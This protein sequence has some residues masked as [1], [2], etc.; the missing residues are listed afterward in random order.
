MPIITKKY[1]FCAAH[2][3]HQSKWS[4]EKNAKVF[5]DDWKIHGH[6]YILEVSI[7]GPMDKDT[8]FVI[9]LKSLNTMINAEVINKLDHSD[10]GADIPW[11]QD[12]Q[13]SSE[14]ISIFIWDLLENKIPKPAH[15][16]RIKILETPTISAEYFGEKIENE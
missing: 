1:K 12:K 4:D 16:H 14:N 9:D 7:N 15:L 3:Y 5:G 8:G 10:I 2:R 11:F 13:P 6:N